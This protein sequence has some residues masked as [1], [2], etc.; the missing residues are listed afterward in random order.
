MSEALKTRD[1]L[2]K[3][4]TG[5]I[6]ASVIVTMLKMATQPSEK[7]PEHLKRE[8]ANDL[9]KSV[10]EQAERAAN[11]L[12]NRFEQYFTRKGNDSGLEIG[13]AGMAGFTVP[14]TSGAVLQEVI[15]KRLLEVEN[16]LHESVSKELI[17]AGHAIKRAV[18]AKSLS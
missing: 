1:D 18:L 2:V 14:P 6:M 3:C 16:M 17:N 12:V 5:C 13:L 7:L 10:E 15:D 8:Q 11:D 4:A 9:M